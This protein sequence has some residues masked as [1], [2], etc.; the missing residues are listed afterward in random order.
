MKTHRSGQEIRQPNHLSLATLSGAALLSLA[1]FAGC[2][3][4]GGGGGGESSAPAPSTPAS[5]ELKASRLSGD[6][7]PN[8]RPMT[9]IPLAPI[10]AAAD[11][12]A[13]ASGATY[14]KIWIIDPAT[15][16]ESVLLLGKWNA[17]NPLP[18]IQVL[19]SVNRVYFS[20]Y[21]AADSVGGEWSL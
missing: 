17:G 10:S 19:Q 8:F 21:N 18:Q 5:T 11:R 14:L 2:G 12:L 1:L 15:G 9:A 6:L 3:G 4:G 7:P 16:Q 20:I 13:A